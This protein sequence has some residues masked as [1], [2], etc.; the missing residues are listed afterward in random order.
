MTHPPHISLPLGAGKTK[1]FRTFA[2]GKPQGP[3][4]IGKVLDVVR[5]EW[6]GERALRLHSIDVEL[7][8]NV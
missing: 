5:F 8:F 1:P 6:T 7:A 3:I 2:L 4:D